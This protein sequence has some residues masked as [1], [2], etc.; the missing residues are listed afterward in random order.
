MSAKIAQYPF[1]RKPVEQDR[2]SLMCGPLSKTSEI[3]GKSMNFIVDVKFD[4][5]LRLA[6]IGTTFSFSAS[7]TRMLADS[8]SI[9]SRASGL[10]PS[11]YN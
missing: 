6:G 9:C 1:S 11:V 10:G 5:P 7:I 2:R 4:F 8:T 3:V